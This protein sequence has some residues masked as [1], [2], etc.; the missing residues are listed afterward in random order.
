[1]KNALQFQVPEKKRV[2]MIVDTDCKNEAD[3]QFALAHHLM[4]PM[5]DVKGIIAAHFES[6]KDL[7]AGKTMQA[8][9]DE[10][11]LM[12]DLMELRDRYPVLHG[13][14]YPLSSEHTPLCSEGAK[15]IVEEAMREDDRPLFVALQGT[16]TDLADALLMEPR[17]ASRL[18]AIWIGGGTWPEGGWEFNL[19]QDIA[20]ANVVLSSGVSL[21]QI[22]KDVYKTMNVT[23]AELQYRVASCGRVGEYLFR[24]MVELNDACGD[25]PRWPH[26]ESWCIGDQPTIGV[27]LEDK[28][29]DHYTL[30]HAPHIDQDCRYIHQEDTPLI[31]VYHAVDVRLTLEDFYAKL[32]LHFG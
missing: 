11:M 9:Y 20:A 13:A 8:S 10:I 25:S 32:A 30:R 3:D 29:R 18:T 2:R 12:L 1:M 23:L 14:A 31:R 28:E 5:F 6:R 17:I 22:P 27:L 7:G 21:W 16:L 26:G 19:S 4:T 15:F 24:Q